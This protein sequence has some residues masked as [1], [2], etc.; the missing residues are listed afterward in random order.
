MTGCDFVSVCVH[1]K[2]ISCVGWVL[3]MQ[4]NIASRAAIL[5]MGN[6][7]QYT[8]DDYE[9]L[10][11]KAPS[12]FCARCF[13]LSH[14]LSRQSSTIDIGGKMLMLFF[15]TFHSKGKMGGRGKSMEHWS[16]EKKLKQ[17]LFLFFFGSKCFS[18]CMSNA[19]MERGGGCWG[20]S[21][22]R[23]HR[24]LNLLLSSAVIEQNKDRTQYRV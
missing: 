24:R 21:R 9:P 15:F 19:N 5:I 17:H 16:K 12:S 18:S 6:I 1:H 20:N 2:A 3:L 4:V 14:V 8:V 7:V 23:I 13:F 11:N 22:R 10:T